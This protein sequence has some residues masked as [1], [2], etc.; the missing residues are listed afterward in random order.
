[1]GDKQIGFGDGEQS[2]A[3]NRTKREKFLAEMDKA[4]PWQTLS[5]LI[6]PFYPKTGPKGSHPT[7]PLQ[8]AHDTPDE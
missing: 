3:K 8:N 6:E 7:F 4:V 1:M 5:N 2:N